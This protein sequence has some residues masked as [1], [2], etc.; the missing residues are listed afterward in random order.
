ME[1]WLTH[2]VLQLDLPPFIPL[3][4]AFRGNRDSPAPLE[5]V[6]AD[7]LRPLFINGVPLTIGS[8]PDTCVPLT[9]AKVDRTTLQRAQYP[10][11]FPPGYLRDD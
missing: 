10:T 3:Q 4:V 9:S 6:E 11:V 1:A 2:L 5:I 7:R 8:A